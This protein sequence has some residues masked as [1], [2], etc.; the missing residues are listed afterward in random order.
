MSRLS[1]VVGAPRPIAPLPTDACRRASERECRRA[2]A[3]YRHLMNEIFTPEFYAPTGARVDALRAH[4][5]IYCAVKACFIIAINLLYYCPRLYEK[6]VTALG[7]LIARKVDLSCDSRCRDR[8]EKLRL[9]EF[10]S[11]SEKDSGK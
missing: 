11:N 8:V 2:G 4:D 3:F 7:E 1:R 10:I 5:R 6:S 9:I